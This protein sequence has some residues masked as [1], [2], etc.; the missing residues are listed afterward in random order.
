M[1]EANV[2]QVRERY[3]GLWEAIIERCNRQRRQKGLA[4]LPQG[5]LA[6]R[7]GVGRPRSPGSCVAMSCHAVQRC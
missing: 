5:E 6:E 7:L 1:G 3:A 2:P 4:E